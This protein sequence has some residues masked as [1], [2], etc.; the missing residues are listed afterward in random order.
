LTIVPIVRRRGRFLGPGLE[1]HA[2][3]M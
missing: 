1:D 2:I 3:M